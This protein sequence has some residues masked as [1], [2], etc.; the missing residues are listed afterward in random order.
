MSVDRSVIR[1]FLGQ[2]APFDSM[3]STS[4]DALTSQL[5]I[6]YFRRGTQIAGPEHAAQSLLIV[7]T[8]VIEE[9]TASGSLIA[10]YEPGDAAGAEQLALG[11]SSKSTKLQAREDTLV[12]TLGADR[13]ISMCQ[14]QP[15]FALFFTAKATERLRAANASSQAAGVDAALTTSV[16]KVVGRRMIQVDGSATIRQAARTM[17]EARTSSVFVAH[18]EGLGI[19]TDRDLRT[20]VVAQGASVDDAVTTIMS[21]PLAH[22][23]ADSSVVDAL[24]TMLELGVHHLGVSEG[25]RVVGAVTVNDLVQ[26]LA[27]NPVLLQR[28]LRRQGSVEGLAKVSAKQGEVALQLI[29]SGARAA[30]VHRVLSHIADT[31]VR[32]LVQLFLD[33]SQSGSGPPIDPKSFAWMS[34][35]SHAR[36]E[37][38]LGSD[39][40]NGLV[41]VDEGAAPLESYAALSNWVCA[42]LAACG[43][44]RCQ[45]GIMASNPEWRQPLQGWR[46][47]FETWTSEPSRDAVM[48]GSIFFDQRCIAGNESLAQVLGAHVTRSV[49]AQPL[50]VAHLARDAFSR[51]P[52]IG[53]FGR[54]VLEH[55]GER[56]DSL[57][58][59]HRGLIP[60]V[61]LART[62]ALLSGCQ[63][64]NTAQRLRWAAEHGALSHQGAEELLDA[65]EWI[66]KLRLLH[67]A[68]CLHLGRPLDN[69]LDPDEISS[70]DRR[71]LRDAFSVVKTMQ[72][73]FAQSHQLGALSA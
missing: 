40:D 39:Q 12:Y 22:I 25:G 69:Y 72:E 20:R 34:F 26:S 1:E 36:H 58:L 71:H 57:D 73:A 18:A 44:P 33:A 66:A 8:G 37:S 52:P 56:G 32:R 7:R 61:D 49:Q 51:T 6:E 63:E 9:R 53:W 64:A 62:Y 2:H 47:Y 42:G 46:K 41:I 60:I 4:L 59:K 45:G 70:A 27:A 17:T 29:D 50:F 35:G 21:T 55:H 67:H 38:A 30:D 24:M 23:D 65:L 48:R 5:D 19:V 13:F 10:C 54:F 3:S 43:Y 31:I 11:T 15:S 68:R 28:E 16:G 14:Q